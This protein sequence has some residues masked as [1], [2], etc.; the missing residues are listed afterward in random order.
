[1]VGERFLVV[2]DDDLML[3]TLKNCL[4]PEGFD[5]TTANSGMAAVDLAKNEPFDVIISDVMMPGMSGIETIQAVK[6]LHPAILSI[7]ITGYASAETPIKAIKVGVDDYIYKPFDLDEFI[8]TIKRNI[9]NMRI[10]RT[11][12]QRLREVEAARAV[13]ELLLPKTLPDNEELRAASRY[14]YS[15]GLGGDYYDVIRLD[16]RRYALLMGDVSGHDLA[17]ALV[18]V[19][20]RTLVKKLVH[21]PLSPAQ[22]LEKLT[23]QIHD[24]ISQALYVTFFLGILDLDAGELAWSNAGQP[25]PY[26]IHRDGR[27]ERL[28]LNSVPLGIFDEGQ[29]EDKKSPFLPGE[30]LWLTTDG[31]ADTVN[32]AGEDF[33]EERLAAYLEDHGNAPVE[34]TARDLATELEN[35][36]KKTALMDDYTFLGVQL[37]DT[38]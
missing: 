36:R 17:S 23:R 15:M 19:M 8:H 1:M 5:I 20:V 3:D 35:F 18:M 24:D 31:V 29:Y 25:P 13:Q 22:M 16:H 38:P 37:R 12:D 28:V 26:L 10:R 21:E 30:T 6:Q 14:A 34:E 7:V 11:L 4:S 27:M 33:G 9:D 2:E 32:D